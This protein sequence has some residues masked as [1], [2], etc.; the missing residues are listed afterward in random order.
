MRRT[1]PWPIERIHGHLAETVVPLRLA[2]VEASGHPRV[3]SLWFEWREGALWCATS[4]RSRLAGWLAAEPRCGFE[5][6]PDAPPYRGVRGRAR[7]TLDAARGGE[8]LERLV[9]RYVGSRETR[10]A[11]WLLARKADEVAV[12]LEPLSFSSLDFSPR[13][14]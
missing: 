12:R 7:A 13:M 9:D 2:C 4:P 10:L 3:L 5:V 1:G 14:R 6:V 11:Q 8:V